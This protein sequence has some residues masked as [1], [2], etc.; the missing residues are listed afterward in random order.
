VKAAGRNWV[1]VAVNNGV[2]YVSGVVISLTTGVVTE[3]FGTF[4]ST[5]TATAVGNGWYRIV[6]TKTLASAGF[7]YVQGAPNATPLAGVA[8]VSYTG[9]GTS[10]IYVWGAQ[11]EAGAFAT[12]YIPTIASTVTR[13][14][15]VATIT[16]SLFSGWYNQNEGTILAQG[17]FFGLG[18]TASDG[19]VA[20]SNGTSAENIAIFRNGSANNILAAMRDNS[21]DQASYT[22]ALGSQPVKA[23]FAYATN[24]SNFALAGVAQT[25]DTSCT[26]PTVDRLLIGSVYA[27]GDFPTNGHIRSIQYI[28]NRVA[29]T[30]LQTLT[31][32]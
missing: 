14:A 16:G 23:A 28:P 15:D 31:T 19:L 32:G 22:V 5:P 4:D 9:D 29:D 26:I 1:N 17:V 25:A 21:S 24:N 8:R 20:S 13:S 7:F 10:G 6:V 18:K 27:A 2:S 12:S 30:Q 3:T 11:L